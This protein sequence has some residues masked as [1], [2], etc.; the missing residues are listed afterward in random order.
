MLAVRFMVSPSAPLSLFFMG[1]GV[2]LY[3]IRHEEEALWRHLSK[4]AHPRNSVG[5]NIKLSLIP[6]FC[7]TSGLATLVSSNWQCPSQYATWHWTSA[8]TLMFECN[9]FARLHTNAGGTTM[10]QRILACIRTKETGRALRPESCFVVLS[11]SSLHRR[12]N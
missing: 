3:T 11:S 2:R 1:L 12:Q 6:V 4:F 9:I 5:C 7:W 8:N 10:G